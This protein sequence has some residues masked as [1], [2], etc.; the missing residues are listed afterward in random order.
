MAQDNAEVR[1]FL[2]ACASGDLRARRRFQDEY[3]EDIYN[4]PVKI[5]G[6]ALEEAGDFYV[7]VFD[8][9]RIFTRLKTFE[10]R[11]SIQF[12][13]FLSYYVLKHLFLEWRRTQKEVD[14]VSLQ[15]PLGAS[16]EEDRTLEDVLPGD[17]PPESIESEERAVGAPAKIWDILAPE[18]RLDIKLLSL[19]ECDLNPEEVRLLAKISGRSVRETLGLV[20]EIQDGLKQKD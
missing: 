16:G 19:L 17:P 15:T 6:A 12:H 3:G 13:T 8:R 18:E 20:A 4:F 11:N 1:D 5:C 14:T 9:D 10:G 7:Y 2:N